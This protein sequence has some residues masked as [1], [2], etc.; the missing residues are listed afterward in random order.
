M[1]LRHLLAKRTG[2]GKRHA[3]DLLEKGLVTLNHLTTRDGTL[4][5][6][7]FDHIT[8][9]GEILQAD[10]RRVILL[11]KPAGILSATT[12]PVHRTVIDLI[13]EP[14]ATEMHL[15]GRLDRA[16][17]GLIILTN[18]SRFSESLTLPERKIPKTYLVHTDRPV[19][20]EAIAKFRTGMSFEKENTRSRPAIVDLL[21]ETS[22][23]LTI[24]E[25]LHH[26][27][28][29]MFLRYGIRVTA[30]HRESIGPHVLGDLQPGEWSELLS[31]E[32]DP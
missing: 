24:R 18:D 3:R 17:T 30:L 12:D 10:I 6:G 15:A 32:S 31:T 11:H 19:P 7:K 25:G 20:A 29:R 2:R 5:I 16:T 28:K 23:R 21:T 8:A 13:N 9:V 1:I 14:W 27:I 22:C 26:Q 4:E